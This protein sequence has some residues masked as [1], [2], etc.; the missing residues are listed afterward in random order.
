MPYI[1][2][3]LSGPFSSPTPAPAPATTPQLPM[4]T[5]PTCVPNFVPDRDIN[6]TNYI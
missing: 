5:A 2:L 1:T 3:T 4:P 6:I